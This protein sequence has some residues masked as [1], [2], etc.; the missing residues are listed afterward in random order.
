[1]TREDKIRKDDKWPMDHLTV[2]LFL[3]YELF[4]EF[5]SNVFS[6]FFFFGVVGE[7]S[8]MNMY[9][10]HLLELG[11]QHHFNPWFELSPFSDVKCLYIKL[12][13]SDLDTNSSIHQ[14]WSFHYDSISEDLLQSFSYFSL[15]HGCYRITRF[16]KVKWCF[17]E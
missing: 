7:W 12:I 4:I 2:M 5:L 15:F 11:C 17:C 10:C 8:C 9:H 13:L 16:L 14:Q 3:F 1:M 6:F